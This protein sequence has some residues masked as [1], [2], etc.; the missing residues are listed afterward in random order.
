MKNITYILFLALA[1]VSCMGN[2]DD[3]APAE[4]VE[5]YTLSVDKT[6]VEASGT[7]TVTFSLMDSYGRDILLD[8]VALQNVNVVC[9][10]K[11]ESLKRMTNTATYNR[12]GQ[13]VYYATYKGV[14]SSNTVTVEAKNRSK[15]EVYARRVGIFKCTSVWC[16]ACPAL[17]RSLHSLSE[18]A[19]Q[20]SVVL[21]CHGNFERNDP[22]SLYIDG[23]DLGTYL[24]GRFQGFA[25]WP[26]IV[27]D[28]DQA[29]SGAA[30][31][32]DV[33]DL[34]M[35][36]RVEYPATCG[37]KVSEV[38]TEMRKED[39]KDV[40]YL[41]AKVS[42]KTSTGGK[43]DLA[44]AVLRDGLSYNAEGVY[45][46]NNDGVFDEVVL[47]LTNNF[48]RYNAQTGK[49]LKADEEYSQEIAFSFGSSEIPSEAELANYR[50][51]VWAHRS[52][53]EGSRM[54][55]ITECAYGKSVDYLLNE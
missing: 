51:A 39:G 47:N 50:V 46:A 55:N 23:T 7:D 34:I 15:Y 32:S 21:S 10:D 30:S 6:T 40:A 17:A 18:D 31:D 25:A 43:Y 12:N 16:S 26:T 35:A 29:E 44:G 36:R 48:L 13:F 11:T 38:K 5:P 19:K 14:R 22:F 20:H 28:L 27:Y 9:E 1:A 42:L 37:I 8:K 52:T 53:D 4:Y 54:D 45:S 2:I 49:D 24:M 33:A 41:V 3:N